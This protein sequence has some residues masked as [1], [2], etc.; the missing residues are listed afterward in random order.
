[1]KTF[2]YKI[3]K[4]ETDFIYIGSTTNF[5]QRKS[6]HKS[7]CYIEND[8]P[9]NNTKLYKCIREND[10]WDAFKM[11][12]IEELNDIPIDETRKREEEYRI[13]L[14]ANLNSHRCFL[15]KEQFNIQH[16][17]INKRYY[18]NNKQKIQ[19]KNSKKILCECGKIISMQHK[20]RHYK[21]T[22]HKINTN[23][24]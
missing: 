21:T 17:I 7:R 9:H 1:M 12:I 13:N 22:C 5:N 6:I 3:Y 24:I 14:G 16:N 23:S 2:I 10:G 11:E 15:S 4:P 20:A 19:E 18:H 8:D